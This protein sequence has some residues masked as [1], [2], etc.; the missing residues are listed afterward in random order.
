MGS[1]KAP[2]RWPIRL[3]YGISTAILVYVA[4]IVGRG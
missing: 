1:T 4:V 3:I 2:P